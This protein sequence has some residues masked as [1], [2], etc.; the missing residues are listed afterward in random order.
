MNFTK[1]LRTSYSLNTSGR[2]L[3]KGPNHWVSFSKNT[4]YSK[5]GKL[6]KGNFDVVLDEIE[7]E[8]LPLAKKLELEMERLTSTS[9]YR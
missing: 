3:L 7:T 4:A 6:F 1:F 5:G 2:L 8:K 9:L